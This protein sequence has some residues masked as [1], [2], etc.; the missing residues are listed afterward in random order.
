MLAI[1]RAAFTASLTDSIFADELVEEEDPS[2]LVTGEM[3]AHASASASSA[4]SSASLLLFFHSSSASVF[5][6]TPSA[7]PRCRNTSML[8]LQAA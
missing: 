4:H 3:S 6:C 5:L 8:C 1:L 2:V 7:P